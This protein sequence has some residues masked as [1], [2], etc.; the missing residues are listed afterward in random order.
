MH[1]KAFFAGGGGY[2]NLGVPIQVDAEANPQF[3]LVELKQSTSN[4]INIRSKTYERDISLDQTALPYTVMG[5]IVVSQSA[6]LT[7]SK[8][9]R[10]KMWPGT[11]FYISGSL[12]AVGTSGDSIIFTSYRDDTIDGD[13]NNDGPSTGVRGDWGGIKFTGEK[14]SQSQVQFVS[15]KYGASSGYG[16]N[17]AALIFDNSSP[18]VSNTSISNTKYYGVECLNGAS[19]DFGGGNQ[20][21]PGGNQFIGFLDDPS[22]Y[23]FYNQSAKT[24]FAKFNFWE[25]NDPAQIDAHIYDQLENSNLGRVLFEPFNRKVDNEP[26]KL[27]F[28]APT[29]GE[30]LRI[31]DD[32]VISW[33]ASDNDYLKEGNLSISRDGGNT[34]T[35]LSSVAANQR[36]YRWQVS[37]PPTDAAVLKIEMTDAS[38]NQGFAITEGVFSIIDPDAGENAPP[39]VP[40]PLLPLLGEELRPGGLLIW[41]AATD[42]NPYDEVRYNLQVD[43]DDQFATPEIN[44]VEVRGSV[45]SEQSPSKNSAT[46][47]QF[48]QGNAVAVMLDTL[49]GFTNLKDNQ[50][51]YWRVQAI[52]QN[53]AASNFSTIQAYFFFNKINSAPHPVA[54]G[55]SPRDGVEIRISRP[56]LSW[57]PAEDPDLSDHTGT[58]SYILQLNT[59]SDFSLPRLTYQTVPGVPTFE[60]PDSLDENK[61]WYWRVQ[62]LDDEG[63]TSSWSSVQYFKV[64]S[65]DEP[66]FPFNLIAPMDDEIV[67]E[68]SIQFSWRKT[69]DP[70]PKDE[71]WY[72]LEISADS[73]F[74][75]NLIKEVTKDTVKTI[76]IKE[77]ETGIYFW[78]VYAIDND[79]LLTWASQSQK[80]PRVFH[81]MPTAV[82]NDKGL[83][84][85]SYFLSQNYPNPFNPETRI[86]F[87]L[88]KAAHVLIEIYNALG[89]KVRI[90]VD[91][92][93]QAGYYERIW[94]ARNDRGEK[95]P[96]GIYLLKMRAGDFVK[97]RK[98]LVVE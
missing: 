94:D 45:L 78:R 90:L 62:T 86:R 66:P 60:V 92:N 43:D 9:T 17:R 19:P 58:L 12:Y 8:G 16:N 20:N 91:D 29:A 97:T 67:R 98:M 49:S 26:P 53:G 39:S 40:R 13:T 59:N 6:S 56:E 33:T 41:Q 71:I 10:F 93:Y 34:Y 69:L 52:D 63:L 46:A 76:G 28:I 31:N 35:H 18:L 25:T 68:D 57:Y 32:Y 4:G 21:S 5:D 42:P 30:V 89:Q 75:L 88:P 96:S 2:G 77:F 27:T 24:I 3:Q 82:E 11:D 50:Y 61:T 95:V 84:F 55:F 23:F 85:K 83:S 64:N 87:G 72:V 44:G 7:I 80:K 79:S 54:E 47:P 15:I 36:S 51:Y 65:I 37:G 14:A 81:F 74:I 1:A 22:R 48:S 38:G 70:D 73:L